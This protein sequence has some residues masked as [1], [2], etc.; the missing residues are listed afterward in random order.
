MSYFNDREQ[1][2]KAFT[3]DMLCDIYM[4]HTDKLPA[5]Q[6]LPVTAIA[7]LTRI[8]AVLGKAGEFATFMRWYDAVGRFLGTEPDETPVET[9]SPGFQRALD[10]VRAMGREEEKRAMN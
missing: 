8:A 4:R 10:R 3:F 5:S 9:L 7:M 2:R 6:R 1:G